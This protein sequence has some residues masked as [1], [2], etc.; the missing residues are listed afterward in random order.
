MICSIFDLL[1]RIEFDKSK[2]EFNVKRKK[3]IINYTTIVEN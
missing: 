1:K 2:I 3:S